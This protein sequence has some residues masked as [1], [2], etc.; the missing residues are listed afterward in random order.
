M[1]IAT[2][3]KRHYDKTKLLVFQNNTTYTHSTLK[4]I[5]QHFEPG[6]VLVVNQSATMPSSFRGHLLHNKAFVE[7][8]LA[9]F[10]GPDAQHLDHWKAISFGQG[11]WT[12]T[13]E[14]RKSAPDIQIG[15]IVYFG[16]D[17]QARILKVDS[18][19]ILDIQFESPTLLQS[20]FRYGRPI[21]YSYHEEELALWDQQT[22]FSGA[23]IS[24]EPP[25]A[26]IHFT[27][28]MMIRLRN[29]G[30]KIGTLLH[31]AGI[32]STGDQALDA[33]LPLEEW[34]DIPQKTVDIIN[35]AKAQE[36]KIVALGTTVL[37]A[38]ESSTE[39]VAGSGL[40]SNKIKPGFEFK[41][42]NA[43]ISGMHEPDSS[44]INILY[45]LCSKSII[46]D[47]YQDAS[48]LGYMGH[49]YGDLSFISCHAS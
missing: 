15:D 47:G 18:K 29:K 9:A 28:D 44:H 38:L 34:Y 8:R 6:D 40:A 32:S 4:Q 19:R 12:Q 35:K 3:S 41:H 43:L 1:K 23:P 31:S 37:R 24:V 22:I 13:T 7:L 45:S 33:R 27:W 36:K 26:S 46:I 48:K 30:V 25:S 5:E 17:L 10:Q 21:Q 49:E 20:L 16:E 11:D 42:A 2:T 39:L 14:E